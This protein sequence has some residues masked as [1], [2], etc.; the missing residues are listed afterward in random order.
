MLQFTETGFL[1]PAEPIESNLI[2]E[3]WQHL[4]Y[5]KTN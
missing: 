4:F 5:K 2:F 1:V 3:K